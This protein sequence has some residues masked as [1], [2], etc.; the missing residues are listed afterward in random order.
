LSPLALSAVARIATNPRI[1]KQPSSVEEAFAFCDNL[2]EQPHCEQV[3]PGPR[4]WSIFQ[5]ICLEGG[6]GGPRISDAWFW[7]LSTAAPGSLTIT[8]S[9]GFRNSTG[10]SRP[11][12][13]ASPLTGARA[14]LEA[15]ARAVR[16]L[17][18]SST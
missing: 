11:F 17:T 7:R 16:S 5:G 14:P 8:T 15:P 13:P 18:S 10:G 2:F 12:D 1:F 4:H 9:G 3:H 6:I